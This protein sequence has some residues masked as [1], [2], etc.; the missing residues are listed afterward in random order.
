MPKTPAES[1]AQA[2]I[3]YLRRRGLMW[4]AAYFLLQAVSALD[5]VFAAQD[6]LSLYLLKFNKQCR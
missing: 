6:T 3:F 5:S 4:R 1:R 2:A